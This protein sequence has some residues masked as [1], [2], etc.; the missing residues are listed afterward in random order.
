M[1]ILQF[2]FF[3]IYP[4]AIRQ[5]PAG[6]EVHI[7]LTTT[8]GSYASRAGAGVSAVVIAPVMVDGETFLPA[9]RVV[10]GNVRSA[11]RV[12]LGLRH[13]TATLDLEFNQMALPGG[14]PVALGTRVAEVDNARERRPEGP[15]G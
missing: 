8:V 4:A 15:P 5:A 13:E 1:L 10:S 9:G 7:R 14:D 11:K 6:T 12:G 2:L 3:S